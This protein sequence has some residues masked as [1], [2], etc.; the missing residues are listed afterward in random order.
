MAIVII[1][2]DIVFDVGDDEDDSDDDDDDDEES[3]HLGIVGIVPG[4]VGSLAQGRQPCL[5]LTQPP[6]Q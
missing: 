4:A 3:L 1:D 6:H 2:D 5:T